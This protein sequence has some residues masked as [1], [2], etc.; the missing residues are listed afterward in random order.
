MA[1]AGYGRLSPA[2]RRDALEVVRVVC[3]VVPTI[4]M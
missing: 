3:G 4:G 2:A 1:E